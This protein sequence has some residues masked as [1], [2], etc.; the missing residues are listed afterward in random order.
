MMN[1]PFIHIFCDPL[2]HIFNLPGLFFYLYAGWVIS[3]FVIFLF[4][5]AIDV[6]DEDKG[7]RH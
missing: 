2:L 4:V 1:Y 5:K 7:E 6:P 3:I